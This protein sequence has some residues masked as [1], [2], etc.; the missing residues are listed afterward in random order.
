MKVDLAYLGHPIL[1]KKA[2]P[3]QNIDQPIRDL[4]AHLKATVIA[5]RGLGLAAPQIGAQVAILVAC[6]P[7]KSEEDM[8]VPGAPKVFINPKISEPSPE[9]WVAEEGCLSIPKVYAP[10]QRPA[11][12]T[13][14][15]Q[16]EEGQT[17][18]DKLTGWP[19]KIVMHENDHLN[20]VLFIDRLETKDRREIAADLERL[21]KHYKIPNEHVRIWGTVSH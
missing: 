13:V 10:V 5:H 18:T 14:T 21:K 7:E 9:V 15:Y 2:Q 8:I 16:D 11:S 4:I 1:R 12:I 17:H 20:G 3:V 19:A 6:F